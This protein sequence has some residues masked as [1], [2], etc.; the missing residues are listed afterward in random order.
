M[1]DIQLYSLCDHRPMHQ[2]LF[3]HTAQVE[4]KSQRSKAKVWKGI[5]QVNTL[6]ME[7]EYRCAGERN[8]AFLEA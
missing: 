7:F 8:Y 5:G 3:L 6:T 1:G 2:G 4:H